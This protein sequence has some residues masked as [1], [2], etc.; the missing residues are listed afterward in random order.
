M[1]A[2]NCAAGMLAVG[3]ATGRWL[4]AA[5]IAGGRLL[6]TALKTDPK[7]EAR[8]GGLRQMESGFAGAMLGLLTMSYEIAGE[9]ALHAA[10]WRWAEDRATYAP[11]HP[12][13]LQVITAA[14]GQQIIPHAQGTPAAPRLRRIAATIEAVARDK[15]AP[16][17]TAQQI[18]TGTLQTD[19]WYRV[20]S[21]SRRFSVAWPTQ[22]TT[23]DLHDPDRRSGEMIS[24]TTGALRMTAI[25]VNKP[26][27]PMADFV[28]KYP[29]A[30][31]VAPAP[32]DR[33]DGIRFVTEGKA[34]MRVVAATPRTCLLIVELTD[35]TATLDRALI[36]R[37]FSSLRIAVP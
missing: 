19:G 16:S 7:R 17:V 15:P 18:A 35:A 12:E 37:F 27:E 21:P 4:R 32:L 36:D 14:L 30:S 8:E 23:L 6:D 29:G 11:I 28:K 20:E 26:A 3:L 1:Q 9:P 24:A 5:V 13:A 10:I 22:A 2:R 25:C 33:F 31:E 34:A